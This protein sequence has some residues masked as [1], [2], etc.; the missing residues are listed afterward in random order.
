[1]V[2]RFLRDSIIYALPN[3]VSSVMTFML[4]PAYAH[5]FSPAQYGAFD[6]MMLVNM[7]V[8]WTVAL[9]IY[10][11]VARYVAGEKDQTVIRSYASTALLFALLCYSVFAGLAEAGAA[12]LSHLVL[13][14]RVDVAIW[15]LAV[16]WM[17]FSGILSIALAQ[18][19]WQLRPVA[20][21]VAS[22]V[23][24][25]TTVTSS[26]L[27]VF[28][29]GLG[30]RG[31]VIGQAVGPALSLALVLVLTRG[32]FGLEF[33]MRRLRE[34]LAISTPMVP[35][36]VGTFLNLYAD[37]LVVQRDMS[38]YG[39]GLY[40]V[41]YRIA[42]IL[43]LMLVG[44]QGAAT[45]LIVA[46]RDDPSTPGD[47]AR[48][49]RL[50]TA[51]SL[52]AF[53]ALSLLATPAVRLLAAPEFQPAEEIVPYLVISVLLAQ[54][55]IFAPGLVIAK[56]TYITAA[57]TA[58]SGVMNLVV[59]ILLVPGLGLVG[60]G[61]ATASSSLVWFA[62]QMY[63]SQRYFPVPHSWPRLIVAFAL[64]CGFVWLAL[65]LLPA[66]RASALDPWLLLV[67]VVLVLT[68]AAL[69][70]ATALR[71][72]DRDAIRGKLRARSRLRRGVIRTAT[73]GFGRARE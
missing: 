15:R 71:P 13:G 50:F 62:A 43:S 33:S 20:W 57:I 51:A 56:K 30:V 73:A 34:M 16:M 52:A 24:A 2:H 1:M 58:I 67:R 11:G 49:V 5:T 63:Y 72:E 59:A 7:L 4:F 22:L 46:H 8:G 6:L 55:Y 39:V 9:E 17:W 69:A 68:G 25:I 38:L 42:T 65:T 44:F 35:G 60:A 61:I 70:W 53:A 14:P 54:M 37:R 31:A 19:R 26:A 12:P 64:A 18:L 40:G 47:L 28:V 3:L 48:I 45:P 27:L 10:Q 41:G 21:A 66:S 32:T 23:G 29:A 36:S